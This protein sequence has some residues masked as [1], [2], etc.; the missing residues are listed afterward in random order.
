MIYKTYITFT[1]TIE[2]DIIADSKE[3][4]EEE[5]CKIAYRLAELKAF[6]VDA[7]AIEKTTI[8]Q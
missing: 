1:Q 6:N 5:G 7:I 3:E 2:R 8:K 4:A